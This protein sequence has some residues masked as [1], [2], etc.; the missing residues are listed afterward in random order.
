M[1]VGGCP[2]TYTHGTAHTHR[3]KAQKHSFL[4]FFK[5]S[6]EAVA[7]IEAEQ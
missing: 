3:H 2:L 6:L 7:L 5:V 4:L 1:G